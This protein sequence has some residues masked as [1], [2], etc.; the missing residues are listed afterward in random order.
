MKTAGGP[1]IFTVIFRSLVS[2]PDGDDDDD[3]E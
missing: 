3:D 1:E 2:A